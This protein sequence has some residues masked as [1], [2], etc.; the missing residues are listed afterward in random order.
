MGNEHGHADERPHDG[1][2]G[3]CP[4]GR[5]SLLQGVVGGMAG[6]V[7]VNTLG[8]GTAHA[9]EQSEYNMEETREGLI[10]IPFYGPNQAG[11]GTSPQTAATLLSFDATAAN[12][13]Q[14]AD[15]FRTLTARA[16]YL[17]AGGTPPP[18]AP[19]APPSD[20]RLLGPTFPTSSR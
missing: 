18:V 16:A 5:R 19:N 12:R 17:T 3:G 11:I 7:A 8:S 15:L 14:L 20:D 1:M 10:S 6:A 9:I 13:G 2:T 4:F